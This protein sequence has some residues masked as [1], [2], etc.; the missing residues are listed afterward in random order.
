MP[1][2]INIPVPLESVLQ[3]PAANHAAHE[4]VNVG[5]W[6]TATGEDNYRYLFSVWINGVRV[7]NMAVRPSVVYLIDGVDGVGYADLKPIL[8]SYVPTDYFTPPAGGSRQA[9][10]PYVDYVFKI[11]DT[12]TG[13]S[14][15]VCGNPVLYTSGTK[16]AWN[17]SRAHVD[18]M[19]A[20]SARLDRWQTARRSLDIRLTGEDNFFMTVFAQNLQ[21]Y[22]I[23]QYSDA[24]AQLAQ[25]D[26]DFSGSCIVNMKNAAPGILPRTKRY[27]VQLRA[28]GTTVGDALNFKLECGLGKAQTRVV[29]FINRYGGYET[30]Y[31]LQG[32]TRM[33]ATRQRVEAPS[34]R[35]NTTTFAM[36][37]AD[38]NRVLY[39]GARDYQAEYTEPITLVTEFLTEQ[40]YQF[41]SELLT[42][43]HILIETQAGG[44]TYFVPYVVDQD[45][46][47]YRR[48]A[49]DGLTA[50]EIEFLPSHKNYSV[51]K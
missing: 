22:R 42:S 24:G 33:N 43:P 5:Y 10:I 40:E 25:N 26:V 19:A 4:S 8:A 47:D 13:A 7:S 16:R 35:L 30:A 37:L 41:Y 27:T 29:H 14:G 31:F 36:D 15:E 50:L 18:R 51:L 1:A 2:P 21:G 6:T 20:Y 46:I 39:G 12:W 11:G 32:K 49:V 3:E 48:R 45:S 34:A 44:Q 23:T 38:A 9:V 17:A 28:G